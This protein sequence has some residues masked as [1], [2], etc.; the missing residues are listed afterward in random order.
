MKEAEL[1]RVKYV[2]DGKRRQLSTQRR[3]FILNCG[4]VGVGVCSVTSIAFESIPLLKAIE[5]PIT[6]LDIQ[7]FVRE[8]PVVRLSL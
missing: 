1:I 8:K 3:E 7:L 6:K 4:F 5:P 2:V